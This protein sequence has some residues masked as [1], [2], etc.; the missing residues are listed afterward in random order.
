M[1]ALGRARPTGGG[2]VVHSRFGFMSVSSAAFALAL[3]LCLAGCAFNIC[4][5]ARQTSQNSDSVQGFLEAQSIL[6]GNLLLHGWSL[7]RDNYIFT[8]APFFVVYEWLFKARP[9]ALAVVPSVIYVLIVVACLA[10][11]S[12]L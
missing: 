1:P 8:D 6:H 2:T 12:A 10:H 5:I 7:S 9:E 11:P 3:L 4:A